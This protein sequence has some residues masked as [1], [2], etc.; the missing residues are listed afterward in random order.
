MLKIRLKT[1]EFVLLPQK[2]IWWP[3]EKLLII[4]DLHVGKG[5]HFRKSGLSIPSLIGQADISCLQNLLGQLKPQKVLF[6]GDLFHSE[7]NDETR[8]F[9]NWLTDYSAITFLLVPGNHDVWSLSELPAS[10]QLMPSRFLIGSFL[11]SH[12]PILPQ[13]VP[14][15]VFCFFGHLHP[16][17]RLK[18]KAKQQM[19]LP[20]FHFS[21]QWAV[22]PAF[23]H[24]TGCSP[25]KVETG[26]R[27]FIASGQLVKQVV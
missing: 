16:G 12:E 4:S 3:K 11:F 5:A 18:G 27:I 24:F 15:D 19:I 2:G 13:E 26:D 22:L 20:C 14:S 1:E 25:V 9:G 6:L 23:S 17:I 10:L 21:K 7:P 8:A